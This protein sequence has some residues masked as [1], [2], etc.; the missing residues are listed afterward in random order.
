MRTCNWNGMVVGDAPKI[1]VNKVTASD[2]LFIVA[3]KTHD[4]YMMPKKNLVK[5]LVLV[6]KTGA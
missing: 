5:I 1:F 3:E 2:N 6:E 4:H